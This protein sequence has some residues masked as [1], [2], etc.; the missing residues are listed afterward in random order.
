[1]IGRDIFVRHTAGDGKTLVRLHRVWNADLHLASLRDAAAA[2]AKRARD[3]G[4][5]AQHAIEQITEEQYKKER[6]K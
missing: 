6:A 3:D 5:P 1:M 4:Q 2:E